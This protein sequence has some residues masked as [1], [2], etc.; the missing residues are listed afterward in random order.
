MDVDFTDFKPL[1]ETLDTFVALHG[2]I[3]MKK[4]ETVFCW[5]AVQF[6]GLVLTRCMTSVY[7]DIGA[8]VTS[9]DIPLSVPSSP[10][11][12]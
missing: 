7:L 12:Q 2:E 8:S 11:T 6:K 5:K 4:Q 10:V 9:L 1:I 3:F